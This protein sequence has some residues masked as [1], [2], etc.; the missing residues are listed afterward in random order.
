MSGCATFKYEYE[1]FIFY[2]YHHR[3]LLNIFSVYQKAVKVTIMVLNLLLM[4]S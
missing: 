2:I 3:G 4:I 1:H